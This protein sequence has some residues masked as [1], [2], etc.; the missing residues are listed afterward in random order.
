MNMIRQ[1]VIQTLDGMLRGS[2]RRQLNLILRW[3]IFDM[4]DTL[5][6]A[7]QKNRASRLMTVRIFELHFRNFKSSYAMPSPIR[8]MYKLVLN[9]LTLTEFSTEPEDSKRAHQQTE[10]RDIQK[11]F[12]NSSILWWTN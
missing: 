1:M 2:W 7:H 6:F 11:S 4:Q 12:R 9:Y 8:C 3:T 10:R 5:K